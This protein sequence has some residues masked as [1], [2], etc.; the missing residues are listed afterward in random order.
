MIIES[1]NLDFYY[2]KKQILNDIN[3][4]IEPGE[5]VALLGPNG[6]G[7][8]TFIEILLGFLSPR[9]GSVQVRGGDPRKAG[10]EFWGRVGVVQQHWNDHPKW[11]VRHQLE[12]VASALES[13]GVTTI[14]P[15][16]ALDRVGLSEYLEH[17]LGKL[18]GGQRRRVDFAVTIL[19]QPEILILDEP[20]TGLDPLARAQIHDL[21][22]DVVDSGATTLITTH[23]LTEAEKIASRI[24]II[25]DGAIIA[26]GSPQVLRDQLLGRAQITWRDAAGVRHV[27]ATDQAEA[28]VATLDLAAISG[29]TITRPTLEDAYI[30][31]VQ[32]VG[33]TSADGE[34]ADQF[35]Q[36]A[37]G[38][39]AATEGTSRG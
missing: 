19:G 15:Q 38:T 25:K 2:G 9:A 8:T 22:S 32:D 27:H 3:V 6:A 37:V 26:D 34:V 28:F 39:D 10:P 21:I 1:Q 12:W 35:R 24:L 7:K 20:T 31:L 17:P 23:D 18:S 30:S 33:M 5:V 13:A 16:E 14:T 36:S 29:L 4:S 11:K